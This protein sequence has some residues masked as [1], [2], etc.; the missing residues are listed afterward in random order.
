MP[1]FRIGHG[2]DIHRLVPGRKLILGGVE[3]PYE[4]G[5][6]GHSDADVVCHAVM[7]ALL[8]AA[9][10]GDIGQHFPNADP[11]YKDADSIKLLKQVGAILSE[12]RHFIGNID[13]TIIAEKPKVMPHSKTMIANISGALQI[14]ESLVSI[15]ATTNEMM[16]ALGRGEGIAAIAVALIHQ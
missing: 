16:G 6:D 9:A 4:F 8:G 11:A 15:K 13:I 1:N 10:L 5:L 12:K 14:P 3:I 2:Y 7:D